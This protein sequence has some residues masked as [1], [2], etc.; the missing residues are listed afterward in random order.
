[1][2]KLSLESLKAELTALEKKATEWAAMPAGWDEGSRKKFWNTLVGDVEH[3]RTK[4]FEKVKSHFPGE[5]G[6]K[7]CQSLWDEFENK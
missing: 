6:R 3:K 1:M 4:C 2:S 7:F 5:K